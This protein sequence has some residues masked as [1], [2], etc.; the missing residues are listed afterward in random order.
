MKKLLLG[1]IFYTS[2]LLFLLA[3]A[4]TL[5]DLCRN[6]FRNTDQAISRTVDRLDQKAAAV[7]GQYFP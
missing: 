1:W 2:L 6:F 3:A 4:L 7:W 5:P